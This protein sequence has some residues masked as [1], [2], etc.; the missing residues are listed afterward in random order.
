[1]Y[2]EFAYLYDTLMKHVDYEKWTDQIEAIFHLYGK[3]PKTIVDLAC[4][5][6]GITNVLAARGYQT[7]G[8]DL[9]EDMLYVAREKARK[10]GLRIPYICQ[11]IVHL[12]LHRP[13]DAIVCMC[14]GFNYILDKGDL[15]KALQRIYRFLNPGGILVFDIS[16]HYKL[17]SVL[18]NHTMADPGED[19]S[20]IWLNHFDKEKQLLEMHL[21]FF[22]KEGGRYKRSDETHLQRAYREEEILELLDEC[23]FLNASSYS[24]EGLTP[25][26]KRSHRIFFSALR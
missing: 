26:K 13:V 22:K 6:G 5:T 7:T 2:H 23:K 10:S 4:G 12:E 1:M 11:D 25:P 16:S 9:S 24:P 3:T 18:G 14:D 15:K 21:T 17:S 8:V 20:L 19:I